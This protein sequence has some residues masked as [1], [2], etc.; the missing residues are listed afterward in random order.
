MTQEQFA[1]LLGY[2]R[3][4]LARIESGKQNITLET[5][6]KICDGLDVTVKEFFDY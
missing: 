3:T 2:D 6:K 1:K 4:F 5:L